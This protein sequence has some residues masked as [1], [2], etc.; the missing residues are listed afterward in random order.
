MMPAMIVSGIPVF[1]LHGMYVEEGLVV[2][3]MPV[4]EFGEIVC[5]DM[6]YE[7]ECV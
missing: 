6:Y 1:L 4:T 5:T 3:Y 2:L 7:W